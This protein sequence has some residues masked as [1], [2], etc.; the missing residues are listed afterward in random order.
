MITSETNVPVIRTKLNVPRLTSDHVSRGRLLDMMDRIIEVPLTLVSAPAGFGKST[1]VSEWA[2]RQEN[3]VAWLSLDESESDVWQFVSYMVHAIEQAFPGAFRITSDLLMASELPSITSLAANIS[4]DFAAIDRQLVL[5]L[6]DYHQL[7]RTSQPH[8]LIETLLTHLAPNAHI[9]IITRRDPPLPLFQ[10]RPQNQL[11]EI[12]LRDLQFTATET[13]E[14]VTS[15]LGYSIGADALANLETEIEGWPAGLRLVLLSVRYADDPETVL[16]TIRGGVLQ[17]R[18]YL[19]REVLGRL[20]E[21]A[22]ELL[23]KSAILN[24]FSAETID[25]V[26]ILGSG[27]ANPDNTAQEFVHL[28]LEYNLFILPLDYDGTWYRYHHLFQSI[29]EKEAQHYLSPGEIRELQLRAADWFEGQQLIDEGIRYA[30]SSGNV[31]RVADII[32]RHYHAELNLDRFQVIDNWLSQLPAELIQQRIT[33]LLCS[34]YVALYRQH[35]AMIYPILERIKAHPD[36]ELMPEGERCEVNFFRGYLHFWEGDTVRSERELELVVANISEA[37]HLTFAEAKVHLSLSR[38]MNGKEKLAL[39]ALNTR[40]LEGAPD[41][42]M[43]PRVIGTIAII[44]QLAGDL[45]KAKYEARRMLE[46]A[47][48]TRSILNRSWAYY[49]EGLSD[50]QGMNLESAAEHFTAATEHPHSSDLR[51]VVDALAGLALAQQLMR[52]SD[53]ADN[54]VQRLIHFD[55]V[56]RDP[57]EMAVALS[58]QARIH[59]LQGKVAEAVEWRKVTN[60]TLDRFSLLLWLECEPITRVRVL[61]AEGSTKCLVQA[62]ELLDEIRNLSE[63]CHFEGQVIETAALQ[64]RLFQVQGNTAAAITALGEAVAMAAPGGWVRPFLELGNPVA[65]LLAQLD[66]N[67]PDR[68][69]IRSLLNCIEADSVP[70]PERR[71][72]RVTPSVAPLEKDDATSTGTGEGPNDL[73]NREIDILEG[74][75]RRLQNKEIAAELFISPHTVNYHL[76]HIYEKLGVNGRRQ[77]V[78][79][80]IEMKFL[81]SG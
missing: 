55:G 11:V 36:Y 46:M 75:A 37:K 61:I 59:L 70:G 54:T 72:S 60:T 31:D 66:D 77:A 49:L 18:E 10:L 2:Q 52:N 6:E 33:L 64:A 78:K 7:D 44:H 19:L 24:R 5:V 53:A 32:G 73:T 57:T 9:V 25:Y 67:H 56:L 30:I 15:A 42:I 4:N 8:D 1:L 45:P 47:S 40:V 21:E 14:L 12:R 68:D 22:Q 41:T 81:P 48:G 13:N 16:R 80:A 20:A 74:L 62:S 34:A 76:K 28:L 51:E 63:N 38:Y 50:L 3:P 39:D 58:C 71:N 65:E 23:L 29:L 43:L 26:C 17:T 69:F 27:S 79:Q 35:T